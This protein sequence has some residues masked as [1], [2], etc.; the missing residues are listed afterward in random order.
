MYLAIATLH[1][2]T[3]YEPFPFHLLLHLRLYCPFATT[4]IMTGELFNSILSTP[5]RL[6][7]SAARP[8]R[9]FSFCCSSSFRNSFFFYLYSGGALVYGS[10]GSSGSRTSTSQSPPDQI[11]WSTARSSCLPTPCCHSGTFLQHLVVT[12]A[13][14]AG[15]HRFTTLSLPGLGSV[16]VL[17]V[18]QVSARAVRDASVSFTEACSSDDLS[19]FVHF[20]SDLSAL[21]LAS[22]SSECGSRAVPYRCL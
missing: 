1:H 12:R 5:A 20:N 10:K 9:F 13:H 18:H 8:R 15:W 21:L 4:P 11:Q 3:G 7:R 6:F 19:A 22:L 16:D 14:E 2:L 17:T